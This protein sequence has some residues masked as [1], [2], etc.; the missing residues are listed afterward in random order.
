MSGE[1]FTHAVP[2]ME[3]PNCVVVDR[4]QHPMPVMEGPPEG[5]LWK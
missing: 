2:Q 3:D 1:V 5:P 4:E